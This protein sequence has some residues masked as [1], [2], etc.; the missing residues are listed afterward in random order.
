MLFVYSFIL[1]HMFLTQFG[2][3][4]KENTLVMCCNIDKASLC[5]I[6]FN[7]HFILL[8]SAACESYLH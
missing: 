7:F 8:T 1:L 4:G 5:L 2:D 3:Q 6:F